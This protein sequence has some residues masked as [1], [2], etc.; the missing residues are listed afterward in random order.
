MPRPGTP[1]LPA[2]PFVRW[3]REQSDIIGHDYSLL[4]AGIP[5]PPVNTALAKRLGVVP[6]TIYRYLRSLDGAGRPT[7]TYERKQIEAVL[8]RAGVDFFEIYPD[9]DDLDLDLELE[10]DEYCPRCR[11]ITTP[12]NGICPWCET[13]VRR[14]AA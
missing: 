9:L 13:Q 4:G 14:D 10:V 7:D 1:T 11:E 2:A 6:R 5:A 3:L 8:T 12:I